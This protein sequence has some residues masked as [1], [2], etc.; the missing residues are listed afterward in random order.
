MARQ[1]VVLLEAAGGRAAGRIA[2]RDVEA[3]VAAIDPDG[4]ALHCPDRYALQVKACGSGPTEALD[5][6]LCRWAD[7]VRRLGLPVWELVR[8]EVSTP[9]EFER[10]F[11]RAGAADIPVPRPRPDPAHSEHDDIGHQ[12][13]RQAFS[14]QLTGLLGPEAFTDRLEGA[15]VAVGG[16]RGVGVVCLDIDAFHRVNDRLGGIAG[17]RVLVELARRLSAVLRPADVLGR[18]GA[19]EFA[20]LLA[21]TTEEGAL[22]VAGRML[23]AVSRPTRIHGEELT[24]SASVGVALGHVG[25]S[26]DAVVGDAEAA[27]GAARAAGGGRHALHGPG[28]ASPAQSPQ[29][30]PTRPLQDGLAHLL[31]MQ[32]TAAAANEADTLHQ[33]AQVVMRQVCAHVGCVLGH[34]WASPEAGAGDL[35]P[36]LWHAA[37]AGDH[38]VFRETIEE[39]GTRPGVGLS[40]RVLAMGRPVW[41]SDLAA[42]ADLPGR[43]QATAAGLRSA[44]AFPVMVGREAVAVLEF[45]TPTPM[46]P[47]ATFLDVLAAVGVQLGR[48]VERQSAAAALRRSEG[49]LRASEARLRQAQA[50]PLTSLSPSDSRPAPSARS[51][52]RHDR[53][54]VHLGCGQVPEAGEPPDVGQG[55]PSCDG[56]TGV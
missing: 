19:D 51:S 23:Q 44:F 18:L 3:L 1:W 45:F 8:A 16:W 42:D 56:T 38:R 50:L 32:E 54:L 7:A 9:D 33:A 26:A 22:A 28:M 15:L 12:L 52:R 25:D 30:F 5:D 14:D 46:E 36:S 48:V 10:E 47:T 55:C 35:S 29:P 27:L 4:G 34:L 20:V 31:L 39:L 6:T 40:G 41:I 53:H 37:D 43:A 17:D 11:E 24:L 2:A 49:R 13:L 21:D